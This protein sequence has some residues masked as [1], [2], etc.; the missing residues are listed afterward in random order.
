ML[1]DAKPLIPNFNAPRSCNAELAH[2]AQGEPVRLIVVVLRV[3]V[4]AVE[5]Q[6]VPIRRRVL[7]R[8]PIARERSR[9]TR[10]VRRKPGT[11][12]FVV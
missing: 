5:V 10:S 12:L 9:E 8:R 3:D 2:T 4:A 1:A 11:T 7:G 6:V